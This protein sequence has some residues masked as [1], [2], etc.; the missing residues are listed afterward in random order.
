MSIPSAK[1]IEQAVVHGTK[2]VCDGCGSD[3]V[4]T[5]IMVNPNRT[6]RFLPISAGIDQPDQMCSACGKWCNIVSHHTYLKDNCPYCETKWTGCTCKEMTHYVVGFFHD[7]VA[8]IRERKL[9]FF[10][11]KT[12][13]CAEMINGVGGEIRKREKKEQAME[14]TCLEDT[15]THTEPELRGIVVYPTAALYIYDL[16]EANI[17]TVCQMKLADDLY[18]QIDWYSKSALPYN[19]L[20]SWDRKWIYRLWAEPKFGCVPATHTHHP[21]DV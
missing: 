3:N 17:D 16:G 4:F 18:A 10:T 12:G 15:G 2:F 8:N 20:H 19:S 21:K 14:R 5:P 1:L 9:S 6:H 13:V 11:K 7:G